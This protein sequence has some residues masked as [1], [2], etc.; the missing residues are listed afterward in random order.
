MSQKALWFDEDKE[1]RLVAWGGCRVVSSESGDDGRDITSGST[2]RRPSEKAARAVFLA[3]WRCQL[4]PGNSVSWN[5]AL[6]GSYRTPVPWFLVLQGPRP[7]D[8]RYLRKPWKSSEDV[9]LETIVGLHWSR[10]LV[11]GGP[12]AVFRK[13]RAEVLREQIRTRAMLIRLTF[14]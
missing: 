7:W 4:T 2:K 1:E 10:V 8:Q 9:Q 13:S 12:M 14:P 6:P 11:W 3:I 5:T